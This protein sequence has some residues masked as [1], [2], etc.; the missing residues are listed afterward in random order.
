MIENV[1]HF[2]PE[3]DVEIFRD[4]PDVVV[5]ENREIKIYETRS[6]QDVA[7]RVAAQIETLRWSANGVTTKDWVRTAH[8]G[9]PGEE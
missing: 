6:G 2:S 8:R 7:A 5:L 9:G 3:L 4:F 1:E